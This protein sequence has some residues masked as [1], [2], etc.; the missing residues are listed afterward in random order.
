MKCNIK[1]PTLLVMLQNDYKLARDPQFL[2]KIYS[3]LHHYNFLRIS[4]NKVSGHKFWYSL[5]EM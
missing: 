5:I 1:I 2:I 4:H 3:L